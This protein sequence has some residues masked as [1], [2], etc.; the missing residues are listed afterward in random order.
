MTITNLYG[1][2]ENMSSVFKIFLCNILWIQQWFMFYPD[3]S[4]CK[5][6]IFTTI[7]IILHKEQSE[8][9]PKGQ[10]A[11]RRIINATWLTS[12][13]KKMQDSPITNCNVNS[14]SSN[15]ALLNSVVMTIKPLS[16]D[17]DLVTLTVVEAFVLLMEVGLYTFLLKFMECLAVVM[18]QVELWWIQER[19]VLLTD[20]QGEY[21]LLLDI[22]CSHR[23]IAVLTKSRSSLL[24]LNVSTKSVVD[25]SQT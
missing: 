23:H 9:I 13:N 8:I 18:A 7:H 6:F 19:H 25:G 3:Y 1:A 24:L 21:R 17:S 2:T 15:P 14:T 10:W 12:R 20:L 4:L 11:A 16:C 5:H 22:F